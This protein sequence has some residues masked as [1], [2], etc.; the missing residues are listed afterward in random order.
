MNNNTKASKQITPSMF[1]YDLPSTKNL[2]S[3]VSAPFCFLALRPGPLFTL[4]VG[5]N[6]LPITD[7][8]K[9]VLG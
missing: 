4:M 8:Y 1:M 6:L 7:T 5:S 2:D 9:V 3:S